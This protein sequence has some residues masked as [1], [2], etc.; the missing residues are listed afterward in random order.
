V[1]KLAMIHLGRKRM[2]KPEVELETL[3]FK[4]ET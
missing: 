4:L 2:I 1:L 3:N